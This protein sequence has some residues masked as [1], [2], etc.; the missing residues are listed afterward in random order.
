M[1]ISAMYGINRKARDLEV[2]LL[3]VSIVCSRE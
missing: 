3:H 1:E 2:C